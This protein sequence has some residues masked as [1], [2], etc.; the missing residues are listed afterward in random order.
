MSAHGD[1]QDRRQQNPSQGEFPDLIYQVLASRRIGYD[2]LMWQTPL[3]GLTAQAFL[4]SVALSPTSSLAARLISGALALVTS[5][6]SMQLMSKHRHHE[7]IDSRFLQKIEKEFHIQ[8]IHAKPAER[9]AKVGVKWSY[10]M[11]LSSY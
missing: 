3:L 11:R 6:L 5:I 8:T 1:Q 9:A 4:F 10:W 2:T 7:M